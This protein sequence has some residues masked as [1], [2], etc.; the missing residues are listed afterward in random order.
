MES[1]MSGGSTDAILIVNVDAATDAAPIDPANIPKRSEGKV[2][3]TYKYKTNRI[4]MTKETFKEA[5]AKN[6]YIKDECWINALYEV[7]G[8]TLL[9]SNKQQRYVITR[10][11]ILE[12]IGRTEENIKNGLTWRD[13][14]PFFVKYNIQARILDQYYKVRHRYDPP[15]INHHNKV[16]FAMYDDDHIY[17][18]DHNIERLSQILDEDIAQF[19]VSTSNDYYVDEEKKPLKHRND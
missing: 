12:T 1:N 11:K 10:A 3:I 8:T 18:L 17:V 16:F 19:T 5:I 6:N 9:S 7:Y 2:A 13:I 14:E 15:R 4:D